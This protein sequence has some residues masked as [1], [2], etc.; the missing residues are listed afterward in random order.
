MGAKVQVMVAAIKEMLRDLGSD[1]WGE[2]ALIAALYEAEKVVANFRPDATAS[3]VSFDCDAGIEQ[4][5][6]ALTGPSASR[7]LDV[8]Y[9]LSQTDVPGR[10]VRRVD[11]ADLDALTPD[12]RSAT[13]SD[14]IKEFVFDPREPLLFYVRPPA[15]SG[16]RLRVSFSAIPE[17][18][19]GTLTS[20]TETTV[21][22][23]F[24]PMLIEWALYRL[25]GHDAEGSVNISRS[26]QHL[27]NFQSMMGVKIQGEKV[28]GP[29]ATELS[30]LAQGSNQ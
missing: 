1:S 21:G 6:A 19:P 9:N 20:D 5:L 15:T 14:T 16:A 10:S 12:W 7:L 30:K 18:Y 8:R 22:A 25:F 13:P 24:E 3:S 23:V 2:T 29:K 28:Y 11:L 4:S 26:Q 27:A 17:P